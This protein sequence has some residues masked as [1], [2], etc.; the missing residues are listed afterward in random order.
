MNINRGIRQVDKF[1]RHLFN[2]AAH[3]NDRLLLRDFLPLTKLSKYLQD[4]FTMKWTVDIGNLEL[5]PISNTP[6]GFSCNWK[7]LKLDNPDI[8]FKSYGIP[9]GLFLT[10]CF[11]Y[12][13]SVIVV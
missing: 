9:H 13:R 11:P 2:F 7:L 10:V 5:N 1:C 6:N 12:N 3:I 4:I 8:L